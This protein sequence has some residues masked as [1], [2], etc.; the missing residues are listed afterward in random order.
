[1]VLLGATI[2]CQYRTPHS[3]RS[4]I[5][6]DARSV[7]DIACVGD[8]IA[9]S[10]RDGA[11]NDSTAAIIADSV[12]NNVGDSVGDRQ[13]TVAYP[14][15]YSRLVSAYSLRQ[16]RTSHSKSVGLYLGQFTQPHGLDRHLR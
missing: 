6:P 8:V 10:V 3:E 7:P 13:R 1:M 4:L 5:P 12:G 9:D 14:T 16:Y 11:A 2:C 15:S